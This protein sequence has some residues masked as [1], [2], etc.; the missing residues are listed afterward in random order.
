MPVDTT[1]LARERGPESDRVRGVG[2]RAA[3]LNNA[4]G[5]INR[6]AAVD[7]V[8]ALPVRAVG[9]IIGLDRTAVRKRHDEGCRVVESSIPD[10]ESRALTP[11]QSSPSTPTRPPST[12]TPRSVHGTS[13]PGPTPS[14]PSS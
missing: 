13:L 12:P 5:D 14:S 11:G 3:D 10:A 7:D 9:A 4:C 1:G 6:C 2:N 8:A